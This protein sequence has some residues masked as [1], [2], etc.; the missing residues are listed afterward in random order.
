M[1]GQHIDSHQL[2][3]EPRC[4]PRRLLACQQKLL[5][6]RIACPLHVSPLL[7]LPLVLPLLL[8]VLL[9]L[10]L[11]LLC[12]FLLL[13]LRQLL[14]LLLLRVAALLLHRGLLRRVRRNWSGRGVCIH[15]LCGCWR[16]GQGSAEG[17]QGR[18]CC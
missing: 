18:S 1:Q 3:A 2:G 10:L 15:L 6:Q 9:L 7:V 8:I 14:P 13:H 17:C 5:Q 4:R 12:A 11:L 16:R